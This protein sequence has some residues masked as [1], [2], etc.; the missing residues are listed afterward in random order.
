MAPGR[1]QQQ[2]GTSQHEDLG[3]E[4]MNEEPKA[5]ET[6]GDVGDPEWAVPAEAHFLPYPQPEPVGPEHD[7][8]QQWDD[9][10]PSKQSL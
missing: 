7:L 4:R 3:G 6:L 9:E 8:G 1:L 5:R 10:Q 2:D